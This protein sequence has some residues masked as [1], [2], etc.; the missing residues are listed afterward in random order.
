MQLPT[1]SEYIPRVEVPSYHQVVN[2]LTKIAVPVIFLVGDSM[3]KGVEASSPLEDCMRNCDNIDNGF[4]R[5]LCY[6]TC[7]I[8]YR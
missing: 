6:I 2:N 5:V 1:I 4:F 8:N 3:V 7:A